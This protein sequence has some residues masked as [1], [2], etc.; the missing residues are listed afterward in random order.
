MVVVE[1]GITDLLDCRLTKPFD[2][3][4]D[5]WRDNPLNK[6]PTLALDDGEVL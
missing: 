4:T 3:N 5:L 2:A 1:A 6:V